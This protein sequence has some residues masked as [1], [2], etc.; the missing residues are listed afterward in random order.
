MISLELPVQIAIGYKSASQ[1]ARVTTEAWAASNLYCPNCESP[2]IACPAN[3]RTRDFDCANCGEQFQLKSLTG[4]LNGKLLGAEYSTTLASIEAEQHPSLIL[5]RYSRT[6]MIVADVR[7]VHRACI[8]RSCLVARN[9]LG[10]NARRAGWQG[11]IIV[12]DQIPEAAKIDI[13]R[14]GIISP[15]RNV[16]SQWQVAQRML[17]QNLESRGWTADMLRFLDQLQP[18]FILNDVYCFE[19]ELGKLHPDNNHIRAKIRQ[20]LQILRDLGLISFENRGEYR[21]I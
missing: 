13:V 4:N 20:Q 2:L 17:Q 8:T 9:P 14:A 21:K 12:L 7:F 16:C 6:D 5:L 19:R 10:P 1:I 11:S 15:A 3:T 18:R